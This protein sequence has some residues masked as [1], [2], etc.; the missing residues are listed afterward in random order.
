MARENEQDR[1]K[2]SPIRVTVTFV[3]TVAL[4]LAEFALLVGVY[5]RDEPV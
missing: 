1:V 5:T 3:F 2:T 4:V